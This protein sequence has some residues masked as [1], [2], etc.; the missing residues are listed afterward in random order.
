MEYN[1]RS[2]H[3]TTKMSSNKK[4][5]LVKQPDTGTV[6]NNSTNLQVNMVVKRDGKEVGP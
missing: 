1:L 3:I 6:H 4:I 5:K 2:T